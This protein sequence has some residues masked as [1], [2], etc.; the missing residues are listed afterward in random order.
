MQFTLTAEQAGTGS[1]VG[2]ITSNP[3][4]ITCGGD[5]SEPYDEGTMV[6][7]TA[8][9]ATMGSTFMGWTGD[10][11]CASGTAMTTVE[12]DANKTCT[13]TYDLDP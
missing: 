6:T 10:T 11:G 8:P 2:N 4:G 7:L 9:A 13:A 5:C 12:V 3:A 1:S